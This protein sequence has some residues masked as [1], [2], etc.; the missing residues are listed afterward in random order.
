M[1]DQSLRDEL[2]AD[3]GR[4]PAGPR[5]TRSGRGTGWSV[6]SGDG[7]GAPA[8]PRRLRELIREHGWPDEQIAGKDGAEAAW[9][10]AQ[11]AIGE[12][13]FE[14]QSLKLLRAC[15]AE[16]AGSGLARGL[17]R[18]PD[19]DV[20]RPARSGTERSGSTIHGRLCPAMAAR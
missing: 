11:H 20:R 12:P 10:I 3:E 15:A 1:P 19:R 7:G 18:R 4:G 16:E 2:V 8:E 14:R 9:L 17:S 6:R 13:D 5:R